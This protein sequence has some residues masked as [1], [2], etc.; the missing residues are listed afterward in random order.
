M[1]TTYAAFEESEVKATISDA[2]VI[3]EPSDRS[4][5]FGVAMAL[6]EAITFAKM[7]LELE[8]MLAEENIGSDVVERYA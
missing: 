5:G 6:D 1:G 4:R 3:L 8:A 2:G 7:I